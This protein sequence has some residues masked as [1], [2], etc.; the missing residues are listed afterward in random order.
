MILDCPN[1][2]ILA[3]FYSEVLGAEIVGYDD[4]WA[5]IVLPDTNRPL[6]AFQQVE[7]F[8][9]PKWPTQDVPQQTHLDIRVSDLDVAET[10]VLALGATRAGS[11]TLTFRVYLDPAG[12]PFCLIVPAD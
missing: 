6:L 1:P 11:D 3:R 5:E 7:N 2:R 8:V 9:A 12:H 10:A 4:D